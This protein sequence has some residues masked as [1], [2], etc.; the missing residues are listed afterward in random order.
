[1]K[2]DYSQRYRSRREQRK[3]LDSEVRRW[4]AMTYDQLISEL[5]DLQA[6]EVELDSRKYQVEVELSEKTKEYVHVIVAVDDGTLPASSH[7]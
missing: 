3:V 4:T 2:D 5:R 1:L 6:C 7:R